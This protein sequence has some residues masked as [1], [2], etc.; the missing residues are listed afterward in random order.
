MTRVVK[1]KGVDLLI[2]S[3]PLLP[4][5]VRVVIAGDGAQLLFLKER[6]SELNIKHRV[7]FRGWVDGPT[8]ESLFGEADIFCLP[9]SYDS[10]GM[11][12]IEAMAHG[13]PVV[14]LDWGP[15]KDVVPHGKCGLLVKRP[16]PV[17]LAEAICR[18]A[19]D[20]VLRT[21]LG[22]NGQHW[23]VDQFSASHVGLAIRY[24]ME[25]VCQ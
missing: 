20:K 19:G 16:E 22:R 14:A 8:K 24:V 7:D 13:L 18:L 5:Y 2:E 10:F 15:I 4:E 6:V 23:V 1:G 12:F 9:S 3:V 17:L 25:Q 11:G 21:T